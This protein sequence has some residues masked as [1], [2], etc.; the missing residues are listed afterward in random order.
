M[1]NRSKWII[2]AVLLFVLAGMA[3]ADEYVI[4]EEDVLQISVWG[5]PELSIQVP[6][7]PD[8]L[9]SIPLVGDIKAAGLTPQQLK[10]A[11]EKEL[12]GYVKAPTVSVVITAVNSLKVY[13]FG[14]G[15]SAVMTQQAGGAITLRRNTTLIQL[16]AQ[17][18]SLKDADLTSS[19]LLRDGKK[20]PVD[21]NSLVVKGDLSQNI[22]LKANDIVFIPN[23]FD[24][25]VRVVGAVK[26]PGIIP[27]FDGMTALDAVLTV[28][29]F[30]EYASQNS[31]VITRKD[32]DRIKNIDVR[33]KDVINDGDLSKNVPLL[34]GDI[35]TVKKG[36]F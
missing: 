5:Y 8:G 35:V 1:F 6:V 29:G 23:N 18:G 12:S 9:I 33:L 13:V 19:Y 32:G 21:F 22:T 11:L 30:T 28:G 27:Y 31:V 14:D 15:I 34:P 17:L 26:N 36:L 10:A 20:L 4:G 2:F 7:R 16:L 3:S 24:K 25:R